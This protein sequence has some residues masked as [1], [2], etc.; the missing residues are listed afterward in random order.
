MQIADRP[1][2]ETWGQWRRS[3]QRAP[4]WG[5]QAESWGLLTRAGQ[6][7]EPQGVPE[8]LQSAAP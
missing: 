1:L 2:R 6:G 3:L 8:F 5:D 7:E 4:S